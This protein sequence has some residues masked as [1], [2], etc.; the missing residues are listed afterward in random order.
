MSNRERHKMTVDQ[1]REDNIQ[2]I[3]N[4]EKM[5]FVVKHKST[6]RRYESAWGRLRRMGYALR[7][8]TGEDAYFIFEDGMQIE[9]ESLRDDPSLRP[10]TLNQIEGFILILKQR[11]LEKKQGKGEVK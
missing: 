11:L 7:K 1:I 5:R 2:R 10:A 6:K 9:V 3:D 4:I 8:A